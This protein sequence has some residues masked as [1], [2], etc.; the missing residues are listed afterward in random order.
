[1]NT[2]NKKQ[3][4]NL[5]KLFAQGTL[6]GMNAARTSLLCAQRESSASPERQSRPAYET[7]PRT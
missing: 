7:L 3:I 1:M 6:L 2:Q 5:K 4:Q